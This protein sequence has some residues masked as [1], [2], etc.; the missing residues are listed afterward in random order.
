MST[1]ARPGGCT[2]APAVFNISFQLL[3]DAHDHLMRAHQGYSMTGIPV[4]FTRSAYAD[5]VQLISTTAKVAQ[6]STNAFRLACNWSGLVLKISK[7]CTAAWR[8]FPKK[9]PLDRLGFIPLQD[10]VYSFYN[11]LITI[12]DQAVPCIIDDP[13]PLFKYLGRKVQFDFRLDKLEGQFTAELV[14][15]LRKVDCSLLTGIQKC[16][17]ANHMIIAKLLW[18]LMIH[19][20]PVLIASPL[21]TGWAC[22]PLTTCRRAVLAV[23]IPASLILMLMLVP[24][25]GA[26]LRTFGMGLSSSASS[27]VVLRLDVLSS[28]RTTRGAVSGLISG[29]SFLLILRGSPR[30]WCSLMLVL[31]VLLLRLT[32]LMPKWLWAMLLTFVL[33]LSLTSTAPWRRSW[34]L[35]SS[36]LP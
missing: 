31:L 23:L 2:A 25:L 9:K 36:P 7:C 15:W 33:A 28:R 16:W 19:D 24:R 3:L 29:F 26:A 11:P 32:S 13:V 5:D 10:R 1:M 18:S 30:V 27:S 17:I 22:I 35:W 34:V 14:D 20:F 4:S 8:Q 12:G 21:V 6:V